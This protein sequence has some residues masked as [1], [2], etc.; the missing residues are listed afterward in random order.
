MHGH[1]RQKKKDI[2]IGEPK[3]ENADAKNL[4]PENSS[5]IIIKRN[6]KIKEEKKEQQTDFD[7]KKRMA[8]CTNEDTI[9]IITG[10]KFF[11]FFFF[12]V[13]LAE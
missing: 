8:S 11:F 2:I 7:K 4:E 9:K 6:V 10:S 3:R 12:L 13:F 1:A 5:F